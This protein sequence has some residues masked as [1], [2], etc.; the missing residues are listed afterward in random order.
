MIKI[1]FVI[2]VCGMLAPLAVRAIVEGADMREK[3]GR[4]RKHWLAALA[5][6][7]GVVFFAV[8]QDKP[9]QPPIPP[10]PAIEEGVIYLRID[11]ATGQAWLITG[12]IINLDEGEDYE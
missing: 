11:P 6:F 7:G 1:L 12:E 10:P 3:W 4:V 9:P 2:A 8:A 5:L